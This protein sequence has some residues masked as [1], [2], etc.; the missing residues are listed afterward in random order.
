MTP[1]TLSCMRCHKV[2]PLEVEHDG[3]T[4]SSA[5]S[6][7]G[8][9]P[10]EFEVS[11]ATPP[12]GKLYAICVDCTTPREAIQHMLE[13]ANKVLTASED[14]IEQIEGTG[15]VIPALLDMPDVKASLAKARIQ[16]EEARAQIQALSQVEAD[17]DDDAP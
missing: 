6:D 17:M 1:Q 2:M 4:L 11:I 13:L 10:D 14:Y 7:Y 3:T 16:A 9:E 5:P 12:G 15:Q 8:F